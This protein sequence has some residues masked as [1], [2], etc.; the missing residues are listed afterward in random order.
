MTFLTSGRVP[1]HVV[2]LARVSSLP[3]AVGPTLG[4]G[5]VTTWSLTGKGKLF[6]SGLP[7]KAINAI[8]LVHE[9]MRVIQKRFYEV[10]VGFSSF[11]NECLVC[12]F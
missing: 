11:L 2:S 5:S 9:S 4:T 1:E 8:E 3:S 10:C 12:D 7:H 6:H